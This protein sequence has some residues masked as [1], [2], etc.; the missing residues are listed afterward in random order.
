MEPK[1]KASTWSQGHFKFRKS[2]KQTW[3]C[4]HS[5][6]PA[7]LHV[8]VG[9]RTEAEGPVL[10]LP[11]SLPVLLSDCGQLKVKTL[12]EVPRR[13]QWLEL[14]DRVNWAKPRVNF[15]WLSNHIAVVNN[16][17][18][19]ATLWY[20]SSWWGDP[21]HK[22]AAFLTNL[23]TV[24]TCNKCFLIVLGG[25]WLITVVIKRLGIGCKGRT[26]FVKTENKNF[27]PPI[28][29][30]TLIFLTLLGSNFLSHLTKTSDRGI[31]TWVSLSQMLRTRYVSG[32]LDF[33]FAQTFA[34]RSKLFWVSDHLGCQML[35]S[36]ESSHILLF[37]I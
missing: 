11:L 27:L 1:L 19:A 6:S 22:T 15:S 31:T 21:N 35:T 25:P 24:Q 20:S 13:L 12:A 37:R 18:I 29:G 5:M 32:F 2:P 36:C 34:W 7:V 3:R 14:S 23:A 16:F 4:C 33:I 26:E 30:Y 28:A 10:S 9:V 17:P 8:F